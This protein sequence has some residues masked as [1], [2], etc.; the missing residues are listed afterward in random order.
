MKE[1]LAL[2]GREGRCGRLDF[3]QIVGQAAMVVNV[4]DQGDA[5][6]AAKGQKIGWRIAAV[7][8]LKG[9]ARTDVVGQSFYRRGETFEI[10]PIESSGTSEKGQSLARGPALLCNQHAFIPGLIFLKTLPCCMCI[11]SVSSGQRV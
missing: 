10:T 2:P 9:E 11:T 1:G 5:G 6:L 3:I 8:I 4:I 7:V